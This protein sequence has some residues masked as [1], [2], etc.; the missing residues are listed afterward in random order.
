M[1]KTAEKPVATKTKPHDVLLVPSVL[2]Q[3]R[4]STFNSTNSYYKTSICILLLH[5]TIQLHAVATP[6]LKH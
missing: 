4:Y 6:D 3:S 5:F 2:F 1:R